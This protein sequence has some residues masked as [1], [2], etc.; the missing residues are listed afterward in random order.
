MG[1][2]L[3]ISHLSAAQVAAVFRNERFGQLTESQLAALHHRSEQLKAQQQLARIR[4]RRRL[5]V[6]AAVVGLAIAAVPIWRELLAVG[7]LA[8]VWFAVAALVWD[9]T[10]GARAAITRRWRRP[11][12][13][14]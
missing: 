3:R 4:R 10:K 2:Q 12:P 6:V 1:R 13:Q 11:G 14:Q 5:L 8:L 7:V 9:A